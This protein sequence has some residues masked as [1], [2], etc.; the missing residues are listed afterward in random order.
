D[1]RKL[2]PCPTALF[3]S[4]GNAHSLLTLLQVIAQNLI[5]PSNVH[6]PVDNHRNLPAGS[7]IL[8]QLERTSQVTSLWCC[9]DER[10]HIVLVA[11]VEIPIGIRDSGRPIADAALRSPGELAS[12]HVQ[13]KRQ[14]LIMAMPSVEVV[15]Q[16]HHAAMVILKLFAVEKVLL[17]DSDAVARGNQFEKRGAGAIAC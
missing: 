7:H 13:A 3:L 12:R 10:H 9:F 2:S 14:A 4:L 1:Q 5:I 15:T 8:G 6:A 17:L 16:Q 11:E